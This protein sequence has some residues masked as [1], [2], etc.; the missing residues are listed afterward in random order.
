MNKDQIE[1]S[2]KDAAG[3]VQ[4]KIGEIVGN[5]KQQMKG[6]QKQIKGKT[7]KAIGNVKEAAKDA[8]KHS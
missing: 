8:E 2:I 6:V 1:G 3:K 5:P 7:Q 4:Q